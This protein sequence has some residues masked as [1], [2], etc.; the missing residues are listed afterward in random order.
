M[1]NNH[2]DQTIIITSMTSLCKFM[3]KT[4]IE[5]VKMEPIKGIYDEDIMKVTYHYAEGEEA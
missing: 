1:K 2:K 3:Q 4:N 5:I